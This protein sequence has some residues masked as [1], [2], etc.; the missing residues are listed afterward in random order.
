MANTRNRRDTHIKC[1]LS[2]RW[3]RR[4][5]SGEWRVLTELHN[6]HEFSADD[7]DGFTLRAVGDEHL[8]LDDLE[9]MLCK[10]AWL[11]L[12]NGIDHEFFDPLNS[13]YI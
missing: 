13:N 3:H 12:G 7:F 4:G 11:V 8:F 10:R 2:R 9:Q 1:F 6:V 5:S